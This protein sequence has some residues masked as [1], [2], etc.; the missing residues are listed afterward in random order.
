MTPAGFEFAIP[1]SKWPQF[2]ALD[3]AGSGIGTAFIY[4]KILLH[5]NGSRT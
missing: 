4:T 1:A 3:R 2:H 5:F